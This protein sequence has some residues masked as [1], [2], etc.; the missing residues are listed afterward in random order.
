M[1]W[2]NPPTLRTLKCEVLCGTGKYSACTKYRPV[3]RSMFHR[4]SKKCSDAIPAAFT[5]ERY[6]NTPQRKEKTGKL[7]KRVHIAEQTVLRLQQ[8]L[9]ELLEKKV[10]TWMSF[11]KMI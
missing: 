6:M 10:N 5:N 11:F 2:H 9:R 3:L 4:W 7:K 8:R 1:N